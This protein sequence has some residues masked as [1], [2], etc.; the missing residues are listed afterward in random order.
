MEDCIIVISYDQ[1]GSQGRAAMATLGG[2][3]TPVQT[4]GQSSIQVLL[5]AEKEASAQV[6]SARQCRAFALYLPNLLVKI[7]CRD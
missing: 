3:S 7:E 4:T 1:P 2:S 6:H 5:D